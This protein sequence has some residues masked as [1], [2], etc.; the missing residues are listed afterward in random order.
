MKI[1]AATAEFGNRNTTKIIRAALSDYADVKV[2]SNMP[3]SFSYPNMIPINSSPSSEF[4]IEK[5]APYIYAHRMFFANEVENYDYFLHIENDVLLRKRTLDNWIKTSSSMEENK[6]LGFIR[7]E[8]GQL[9]DIASYLEAGVP[10]ISAINK[11]DKQFILNNMNQSCYILTRKQLKKCLS[12]GNYLI[13][14]SCRG[15]YGPVE[16]AAS[17]VFFECG[18][19]RV[20]P[21]ENLENCLVEH[22]DTKYI[23]A[24]KPYTL[25]NLYSDLE[26]LK[27]EH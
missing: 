3:N 6:V 1:L 9:I 25:D 20:F 24:Q 10:A 12:S 27:N 17:N 11:K 7:S 14:P 19:T 18:L 13:H 23:L 22:L 21:F 16:T 8:H 2:F 15:G 4:S 26:K 5:Y